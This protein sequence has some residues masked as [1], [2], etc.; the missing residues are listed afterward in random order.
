RHEVVR[1]GRMIQAQLV[2]QFVRQDRQQIDLAERRA[3]G[4]SA[5]LVA[6]KYVRELGLVGRRGIDEPAKALSFL[7]D[8]DNTGA[9]KTHL[10]AGER[11]D[12]YLYALQGGYVGGIQAG[13]SP[14]RDR[15]SQEWLYLRQGERPRGHRLG[16][17]LAQD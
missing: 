17:R 3:A 6:R 9:R 8:P 16:D 14:V 11:S 12:D 2:T 4:Q 7:I 1:I 5:G 15:L 10:G 13:G